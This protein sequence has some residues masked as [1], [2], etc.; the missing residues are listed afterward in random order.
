MENLEEL[1]ILI[2]KKLKEFIEKYENKNEFIVQAIEDK[3]KKEELK[4]SYKFAFN[5]I[6][7]ENKFF[8]GTIGD[9]IS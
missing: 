4:N 1:K 7:E 9:G 2:P 8:E 3:I 6:K 5:E